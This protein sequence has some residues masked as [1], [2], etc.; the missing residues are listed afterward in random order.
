MTHTFFKWGDLSVKKK[1]WKRKEKTHKL[2][3]DGEFDLSWSETGEKKK[4]LIFFHLK[5]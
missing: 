4:N 5:V 1:E 3:S 2:I